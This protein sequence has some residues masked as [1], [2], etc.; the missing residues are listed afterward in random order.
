MK[1]IV[2]IALIA[3]TAFH[4]TIYAQDNLTCLPSVTCS[5]IQQPDGSLH[6]SCNS[7][8]APL[9]PWTL[10]GIT[11]TVFNN[12]TIPLTST[13]WIN[14]QG[15]ISNSCRYGSV[16]IVV[17]LGR[18]DITS[19]IAWYPQDLDQWDLRPSRANPTTGTCVFPNECYM[20]TKPINA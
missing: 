10:Q 2:K 7:Q 1:Y 17:L 8:G 15:R 14:L 19:G 16:G 9:Q 5:N 4:S 3:V 12:L 6:A 20:T 13:V 18:D 11:A